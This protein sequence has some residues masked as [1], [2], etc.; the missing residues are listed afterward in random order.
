[1]IVIIRSIVLKGIPAMFLKAQIIFMALFALLVF[2]AAV[3][4]LRSSIMGRG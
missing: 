3:S 1:M 2:I 4:R